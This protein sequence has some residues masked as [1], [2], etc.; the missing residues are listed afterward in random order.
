[1]A[2]ALSLIGALLQTPISDALSEFNL[3]QE[4]N[5][6]LIHREGLLG[7]LVLVTEMLEQ[8]NFGF[9]RE[10]LGKFSLTVEDLFLIERDAI[11]EYESYDNKES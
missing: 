6:A 11:I 10:V 9:I 1:M 5:D 2:G 3:S 4:I 8:E 7:T